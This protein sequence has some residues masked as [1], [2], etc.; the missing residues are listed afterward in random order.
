MRKLYVILLVIALSV[1]SLEVLVY[2]LQLSPN[3]GPRPAAAAPL[4][5]P[6]VSAP[7]PACNSLADGHYAQL[8][9]LQSAPAESPCD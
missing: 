1:G 5:A 8:G 3:D 6:A 4:P 7:S 2:V 9:F